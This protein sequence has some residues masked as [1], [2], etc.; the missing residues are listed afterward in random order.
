MFLILDEIKNKSFNGYSYATIAFFVSLGISTY[1]G[2]GEYKSYIV[3]FVQALTATL[4]VEVAL[5]K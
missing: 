5:K 2:S 4:F 1:L 3:Y